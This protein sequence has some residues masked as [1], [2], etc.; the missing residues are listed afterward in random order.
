M[1]QKLMV[2][3]A[4]L[5]IAIPCAYAQPPVT[6][7]KATRYGEGKGKIA[8]VRDDDGLMGIG[9]CMVVEVETAPLRVANAVRSARKEL[10]QISPEELEQAGEDYLSVHYVHLAPRFESGT[11]YAKGGWRCT[12]SEPVKRIL[13]MDAREATKLEAL[14]DVEG[15]TR[16]VTY[17]SGATAT[18]H[19]AVARFATDKA[20]ALPGAGDLK[21]AIVYEGRNEIFTIKA[22]NIRDLSP[23]W[24]Q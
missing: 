15:N 6:I 2:A 3:T 18:V 17:G 10:R 22:K 8:D 12:G 5:S 13:L 9:V 21:V 11:K 20:L 19:S 4:F 7:D 14:G 16:E 1:T 23:P 24:A